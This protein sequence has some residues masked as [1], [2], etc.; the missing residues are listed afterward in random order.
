MLY[1]H[2]LRSKA[3]QQDYHKTQIPS[4]REVQQSKKKNMACVLFFLLSTTEPNQKK[5]EV[6]VA[7]KTITFVTET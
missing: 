4:S 1:P 6:V 7:C 5:I 2:S 3:F